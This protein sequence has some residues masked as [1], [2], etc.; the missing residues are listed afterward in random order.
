MDIVGGGAAQAG[1]AAV[2]LQVSALFGAAVRTL[3]KA[4]EIRRQVEPPARQS[5][6]ADYVVMITTY[7]NQLV[8]T[9]WTQG[10]DIVDIAP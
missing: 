6:P 4:C 2:L 5:Q 7:C 9:L 10:L 3:L 1:A 8:G